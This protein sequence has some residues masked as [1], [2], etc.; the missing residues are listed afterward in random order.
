SASDNIDYI[1]YAFKPEVVKDLRMFQDKRFGSFGVLVQ[2]DFI[3]CVLANSLSNFM[4]ELLWDSDDPDY[5]WDL[6]RH[7]KRPKNIYGRRTKALRHRDDA[8]MAEML[9]KTRIRS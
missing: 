6:K 1:K 5:M 4:F 8:W 7:P 9:A 2:Q 3:D